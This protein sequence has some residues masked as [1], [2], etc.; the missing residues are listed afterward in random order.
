MPPDPRL[1]RLAHV[2]H[3]P[4]YPGPLALRS[5]LA[6]RHGTPPGG[7]RPPGPHHRGLPEWAAYCMGGS[8]QARPKRIRR[9]RAVY[10]DPLAAGA[11]DRHARYQRLPIHA[12][13]QCVA[14]G[15][16]GGGA[17][18]R[19]S[20]RPGRAWDAESG[21][22]G[23]GAAAHPSAERADRAEVPRR[24]EQ[25]RGSCGRVRARRDRLGDMLFHLLD[26]DRV[27]GGRE[28]DQHPQQQRPQAGRKC[29]AGCR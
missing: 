25:V 5:S 14:L 15:A 24:R 17:R 18:S 29:A 12:S 28:K 10:R 8:V 19:H 2:G 20:P 26:Q 13:A 16:G 3:H 7:P 23:G 21:H 11:R 27:T 6:G 22:S 9:D 1:R 4:E